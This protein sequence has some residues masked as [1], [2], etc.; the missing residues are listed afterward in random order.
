MEPSDLS[1]EP[2]RGKKSF[3]ARLLK[4]DECDNSAT[5]NSH[6]QCRGDAHEKAMAPQQLTGQI[7]SRMRFRENGFAREV[8]MNIA[9]QILG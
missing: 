2:A 5:Q 4:K 3:E 8:V 7:G 1:D 9:C 6:H